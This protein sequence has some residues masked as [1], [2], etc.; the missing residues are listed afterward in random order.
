MT[1]PRPLLQCVNHPQFTRLSPTVYLIREPDCSV[2]TT[3][4]VA[5]IAEFIQ[6]DAEIRAY[7][8]TSNFR[9]VPLGYTDFCAA[10][11]NGT[12]VDDPRQFSTIFLAENPKDNG[13]SP[14][15][16]PVQLSDFF[17]TPEQLGNAPINNQPSAIQSEITLEYAALM[18]AKQKRQR[19]FIEERQARKI[20]S[21]HMAH[22]S[23]PQAPATFNHNNRRCNRAPAK[24]RNKKPYQSPTTTS[25][26]GTS[27]HNNL[28]APSTKD[29]PTPAEVSTKSMDIST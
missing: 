24:H 3:V 29:T 10:W 26:N 18:A 20:Q 23:P 19:E 8:R 9:S 25:N 13:V 5:Q 4:H 17:I 12:E 21:Q 2:H 15:K 16:Y 11:N 14:S 1:P 6:F 27:S 7:S 28:P 22:V